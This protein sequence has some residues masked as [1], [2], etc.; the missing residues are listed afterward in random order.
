M[1]DVFNHATIFYVYNGETGERTRIGDY[2]ALVGYLVD[3]MRVLVRTDRLTE[4]EFDDV[5]RYREMIFHL[6]NLSGHDTCWKSLRYSGYPCP[7]T[8]YNGSGAIIDI[9]VTIPDVKKWLLN[10]WYIN[11]WSYWLEFS[12]YCQSHCI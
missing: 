2:T 12:P 4:K 6:Q 8:F 7:Y 10:G 11:H 9:R 1:Y 5:M 3:Q